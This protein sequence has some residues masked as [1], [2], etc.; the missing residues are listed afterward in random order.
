MIETA[1][2]DRY[3][4]KERWRIARRA[5]RNIIRTMIDFLRFPIYSKED[6][7]NLATSIEGWEHLEK[8]LNESPGAVLGLA[9][10]IGSW[11]YSGAFLPNRGIPLVAVGRE[12]RETAITNLMIESRTKVGIQHIPRSKFGNRQLIKC[13]KTKGTV[14]GLLADQNGGRNGMFVPFFGKQASTVRGPAFFALRYNL[15][16][17]PIFGIWD[18]MKYKIIVMPPV[19]LVHHEDN[20]EAIRLTTINIQKVYEKI[21]SDYPDQWMWVH[22]RWKTRPPE[23]LA[24]KG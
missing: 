22:D 10:H 15:P 23:E 14:V 1:F 13:L 21:I 20:E 3:T 12:Q 18:D 6:M 9:G 11:E 7:L 8:A 2:G 16:I 17:V 4:P 19:E 24:A 5:Y